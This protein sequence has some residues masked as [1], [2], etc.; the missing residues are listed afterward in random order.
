MIG[1]S[2]FVYLERRATN[3]PFYLGGYRQI[4]VFLFGRG[5]LLSHPKRKTNGSLI[6]YLKKEWATVH[7]LGK[8]WPPIYLSFW[9]GVGI[10]RPFY[11]EGMATNLFF[12]LERMAT[13]LFFYLEGMA[14]NLS[15]YLG[16]DGHLSAFLFGRGSHQPTF[17]FGSGWAFIYWWFLQ[18]KMGLYYF[19]WKGSGRLFI[20][21]GRDGH[22]STFLMDGW[23]AQMDEW[24]D[25]WMDGWMDGG[26]EHW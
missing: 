23:L 3:L 26:G 14:T 17:L 9:E 11:L 16:G 1:I 22:Q 25:G 7:Q 13:N 4:S 15:F 5:W 12:Y 19:I 20:N 8:W 18:Q 6:F 2:L 21:L 24:L 10:Y